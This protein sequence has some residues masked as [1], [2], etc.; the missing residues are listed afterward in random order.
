MKY[1]VSIILIAGILS[2]CKTNEKGFPLFSVSQ[3]EKEIIA[4]ADYVEA[5]AQKNKGNLDKAIG[6]LKSVIKDTKHPASAHFELSK[7]YQIQKKYTEALVES[8]ITINLEPENKWYLEHHI[9]LTKM[10][11]KFDETTAAFKLREKHFPKNT[12]FKIEF[13]D[14]YIQ[15]KQFKKALDL[16]EVIEKEIGVSKTINFNK[17]IIYS[18]LEEFGKAEKEINKLIK[19]FP[20]EIEY[21]I[22]YA[23]YLLEKDRIDD[24]LKLY[25][26][27]LE[28]APNNPYILAEKANHLYSVGKK[29]SALLMYETV[30][31]DASYETRDR[32]SILQRFMRI[33]EIDEVVQQRIGMYLDLAIQAD[34]NSPSVNTLAAD[35][36]FRNQN[37]NKAKTYYTTIL[38]LKPNS[39]LI[40]RQLLMS[41]YNLALFE[42]MKADAAKSLE[43]FPTQP[44]LYLYAGIAAVQLKNYEEALQFLEDGLSLAIDNPQLQAQ[45]HSNL[46]DLHHILKNYAKSD[47][48]FNITLSTDPNNAYALNNYAYYLS[49][50]NESL[51]KAQA[52]SKKANELQPNE[53]SFED[54]YGWILYQ[55]KDYQN[56]LI[57][58]RKSEINGGSSS[59]VINNHLGDVQYRLGNINEAIVYWEK[60]K[61]L[62]DSSEKL[63]KKI[64]LRKIV[65]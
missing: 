51:S 63:L 13:S 35:H 22:Q 48:Y 52:M 43:L 10:L 1:I 32:V 26:I 31:A 20:T 7:I 33:G 36:F 58:L 12:E 41:D 65:D 16:Y 8:R 62:G 3:T 40:W 47:E 44:E 50:R 28:Y 49:E 6:L 21:Y 19:T 53:S 23:N 5:I 30:I 11:G 29:D 45:F 56:A 14:F 9:L 2:S 60:A 55:L 34:P 37:Y 46:A 15:T 18:R 64:K 59:A 61:F 17:F 25:E 39:F 27:A 4:D 42:E 57:W 24:A 38:E 54:T